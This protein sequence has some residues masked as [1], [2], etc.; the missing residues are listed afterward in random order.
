M[1][2]HMHTRMEEVVGAAGGRIE[3]VHELF[4]VPLL[5]PVLKRS[6]AVSAAAPPPGY[7]VHELGGA[8][9]ASR[10]DDGVLDPWNRCWQAPNV[11]VTDGACWPT[12]GWQSPTLTE[13]AVTWRACAAAARCR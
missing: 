6:P 1:V 4:V 9:M 8:P 10:P 12:A 13:M 7:Y 2:A 5:E 11:L 3:P